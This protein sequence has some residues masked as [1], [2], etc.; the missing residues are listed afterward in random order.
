[1]K[2]GDGIGVEVG[3]LINSAVGV[4]VDRPKTSIESILMEPPL[5]CVI[6]IVCDESTSTGDSHSDMIVSVSD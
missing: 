6:V 3:T 1:M 2:A 4:G 5:M